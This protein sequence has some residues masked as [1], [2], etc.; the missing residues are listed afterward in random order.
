MASV[1]GAPADRNASV[2]RAR[3]STAGGNPPD[4]EE[5]CGSRDAGRLRLVVETAEQV[6]DVVVA[7]EL[8][9]WQVLSVTGRQ[10]LGVLEVLLERQDGQGSGPWG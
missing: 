9:G 4:M 1:A 10:E 5:P 6:Q 7:G 3:R 8:F 2:A